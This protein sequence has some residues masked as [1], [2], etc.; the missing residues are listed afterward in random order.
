M[1]KGSRASFNPGHVSR[2]HITFV[3]N[4]SALSLINLEARAMS[5]E[6]KI[7]HVCTSYNF[8]DISASVL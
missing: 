8:I 5:T 4:I 2:P 7:I 3:S 6:H 1:G